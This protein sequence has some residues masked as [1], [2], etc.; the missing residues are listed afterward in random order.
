M[1]EVRHTS[2]LLLFMPTDS[3]QWSK[4]PCLGIVV[5]RRLTQTRGPKGKY[6]DIKLQ[7]TMLTTSRA[8]V[9]I[10]LL[11]QTT[12]FLQRVVVD[13]SMALKNRIFTTFGG[14]S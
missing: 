12:F 14:F 3:L 8:W 11:S 2:S 9:Q 10:P 7:L 6:F 1:A 5:A 4:A 13:L